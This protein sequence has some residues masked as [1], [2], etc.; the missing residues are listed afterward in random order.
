MAFKWYVVQ[1]YASFED[2]VAQMIQENVKKEALEDTLSEILIPSE[3]VK[4]VKRGKLI[5]RS[6]RLHQ[7]YVYIHANLTDKLYHV[8]TQIPRV[9]GFLS[10]AYT[11]GAA[12]KRPL[13]VSEREIQAIR[14]MISD[15]CEDK[16]HQIRFEIGEKV[17]ITDG[18][19][20]SFVGYIQEIDVS[21]LRLKLSVSIFNR[22]T[23]V[24]LEFHQ[25]K[26][27]IHSDSL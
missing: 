11:K 15:I 1:V 17:Q 16:S 9:S 14:L 13:E 20:Q 18:P 21:K 27:A 12:K 6:R 4:V 2:K 7:G 19:F 22:D 3:A 25:V 10:A 24:E 26:K 5:E 23:P 8:I